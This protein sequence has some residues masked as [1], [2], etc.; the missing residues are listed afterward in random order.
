MAKYFM[1]Q[2]KKLIVKFNVFR[3]RLES[4]LTVDVR[5]DVL[6]CSLPSRKCTRSLSAVRN[7]TAGEFA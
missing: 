5:S 7:V 4:N 1:I 6:E 2:N 3:F